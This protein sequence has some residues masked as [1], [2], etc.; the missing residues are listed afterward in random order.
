MQR[1]LAIQFIL[2]LLL[3]SGANSEVVESWICQENPNGNWSEILITAKINKGRE[4]GVVEVAGVKY[5]SDFDMRGV[6]RHWKFG[7]SYEHSFA[8]APNGD[9]SYYNYSNTPEGEVRK[10][11][12][13]PF[14]KQKAL[15]KEIPAKKKNRIE[16]DPSVQK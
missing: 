15:N 5:L 9:G 14:C 10:P 4:N 7:P 2:F 6:D 16:E 8:V 1:I 3:I 11:K 12:I 13:R